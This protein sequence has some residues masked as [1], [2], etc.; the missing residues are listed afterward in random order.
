[1]FT[2]D[3]WWINKLT[4][5]KQT[6]VTIT[7]S[8]ASASLREDT[9]SG[10]SLA[11]P[12]RQQQVGGWDCGTPA[13]AHW[14]PLLPIVPPLLLQHKH[15]LNRRLSPLAPTFSCKW[16]HSGPQPR[17]MLWIMRMNF[18]L[19]RFLKTI[20]TIVHI[21]QSGLWA[22]ESIHGQVMDK[23][24]PSPLP[25]FTRAQFSRSS[26]VWDSGRD[27]RL[28]TR[29]PE[30]IPW[31]CLVKVDWSIAALVPALK[32]GSEIVWWTQK[33]CKKDSPNQGRNC[34]GPVITGQTKTQSFVLV[35]PV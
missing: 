32:R 19:R 12:F 28:F 2:E 13:V 5:L 14:Y 7:R 30:L 22:Q 34:S 31:L 1:M 3:S 16:A 18:H 29:F 35:P 15:M 20:L 4:S 6:N 26:W 25:G 33:G 24:N 9:I 17:L 10:H 27:T 8:T 21:K 11:C 23:N